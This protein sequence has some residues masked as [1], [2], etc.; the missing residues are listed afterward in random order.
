MVTSIGYP[1]MKH[2]HIKYQ[3]GHQ[4]FVKQYKELGPTTHIRIPEYVIKDIRELATLLELVAQ[5]KGKEF[6]NKILDNVIVG[7]E[8]I[9]NE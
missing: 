5:K 6:V 3:K 4:G 7:L 9:L 1:V 2:E 8:D